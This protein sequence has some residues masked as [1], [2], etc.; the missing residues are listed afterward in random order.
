MIKARAKLFLLGGSAAMPFCVDEFVRAAGG[1]RGRVALLLQGGPNM[2]RYIP[3]YVDPLLEAG[4]GNWELVAPGAD[5][6]LDLRAA[7]RAIHAATAVLI[8]GG[9]TP[10]YHRLY[11]DGPVSGL[12]RERVLAGLPYGGVSA[13]MLIAGD[14]CPLHADETGEPALRMVAGL[15][16]F[17]GVLCEPHFTAQNRLPLLQAAML[18]SGLPLGFGVDDDTCLVLAPGTAPRALGGALHEVAAP[19]QRQRKDR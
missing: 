8:G 10:A 9:S 17:S 15:G 5:G 2:E 11:V 12:L 16:L 14:A 7:L 18:H 3:G 1:G 6:R 13:G 4:L 19:G